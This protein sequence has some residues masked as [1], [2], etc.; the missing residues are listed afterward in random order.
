MAWAG[1]LGRAGGA[2]VQVPHGCDAVCRVRPL[3][4]PVAPDAREAQRHAARILPA[5]L[6][7]VERNLDDKLRTNIHGVAVAA[8]LEGQELL[9]LPGEHLVRHPLERLPEHDEAALTRISAGA[10]V[11]VREPATAAPVSPFGSE[12]H[13]VEGM[14]R[15]HLEPC[16][17]ARARLI[18]RVER[19]GYESLVSVR[20]RALEELPCLPGVRGGDLRHAVSARDGRGEGGA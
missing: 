19:L 10:E 13:E 14:R 18:A 20:E 3:V 1:P 17:A 16:G 15:L 4:G 5:A 12:H 8:G 11:E 9:S 7:A 6:D 2:P